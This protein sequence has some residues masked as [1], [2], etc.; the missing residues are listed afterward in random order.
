MKRT[1]LVFVV[2]FLFACAKENSK[3]LSEPGEKLYTV[4]GIVL[5]RNTTENSLSLDHE[6]IPGFMSAMKMDYSVRGADVK[7]L[8]A[9]RKRIEAKLHVTEQ[10]YWI[11]DVKQIP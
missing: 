6:E 8:P 1:A 9:D 7:T 10:A 11:T 3:P 2:L 4:R 5:S